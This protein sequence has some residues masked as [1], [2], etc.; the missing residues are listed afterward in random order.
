MIL[1]LPS[2]LGV[3]YT[4]YSNDTL[5]I[6]RSWQSATAKPQLIDEESERRCGASKK[7]G[8]INQNVMTFLSNPGP[9]G[10]AINAVCA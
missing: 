5:T 4:T 10:A 7:P 8:F 2:S 3:G 6:S 1:G 9:D